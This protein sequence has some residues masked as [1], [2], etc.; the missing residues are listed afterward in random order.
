[1]TGTSTRPAVAAD[2]DA[3]ATVASATF[4]F[5]CPPDMTEA[6]I[7]AFVAEHLTPERFADY[8]ADP[9]RALL[10]AEG[11][12]EPLGY[13][14][15]VGYAM[16]VFGEPYAEDVRAVVPQRPA[17]E[18][19][20]IYVVPEAAGSGLAGDLMDASV[21]IARARGAAVLWL[22]TNQQNQRAQR[23]YAKSGFAHVGTRRFWVG[24]HWEDDAVFALELR[25]GAPGDAGLGQRGSLRGEDEV[26]EVDLEA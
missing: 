15:P 5:A 4:R 17:A 18:L 7:A 1:M 6:A 10:I 21:A 26:G 12:G 13:T 2:A 25:P 22:G 19:S 3:L 23:F 9:D 24:D 14:V 20:K 11:A 8:L 16:L